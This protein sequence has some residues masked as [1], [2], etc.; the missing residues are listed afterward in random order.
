M[1]H[2]DQNEEETLEDAMLSCG[3]RELNR[4]EPKKTS[5]EGVK[6][7]VAGAQREMDKLINRKEAPVVISRVESD[8][9]R[10]SSPEWIDGSRM[11]LTSKIDDSET[12]VVTGH[13]RSQGCV[14]PAL[15]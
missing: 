13:L 9:I 1:L 2:V 5:H 4:N 15:K 8:E 12:K 14:D 6:K 7:I 3:R 11:I 10:R